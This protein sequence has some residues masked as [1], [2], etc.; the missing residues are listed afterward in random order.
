MI[1]K[2]F[3]LCRNPFGQSETRLAFAKASQSYFEE[4]SLVAF[5]DATISFSKVQGD[6]ASGAQKLIS[7]VAGDADRACCAAVVEQLN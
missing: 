7:Q 6:A 4:S 3:N 5:L 1:G 2:F